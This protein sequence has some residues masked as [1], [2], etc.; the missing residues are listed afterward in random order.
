MMITSQEQET[1]E[2]SAHSH[3][4]LDA[5]LSTP[6]AETTIAIKDDDSSDSSQQQEGD[7]AASQPISPASTLP[8]APATVSNRRRKLKGSAVTKKSVRFN[9]SV[10][11]RPSLHKNDYTNQETSSCW[12][13]RQEY[14]SIRM[15]LLKTLKHIQSGN[16]LVGL[17]RRDA[18]TKIVVSSVSDAPVSDDDSIVTFKTEK[19]EPMDE[20]G[21]TDMDISNSRGLENYTVKGSLKSRVRKIRQKS[22]WEVLEEQDHQVDEAEYQKLTYLFYDD[23]AI[24]QA[25]IK[26]TRSAAAAARALGMADEREA[27]DDAMGAKLPGSRHQRR[28]SSCRKVSPKPNPLRRIQRRLSMLSTRKVKKSESPPKRRSLDDDR[29]ESDRMKEDCEK[30]RKH[31]MALQS[32]ELAWLT[33]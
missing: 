5:K 17:S 28:R 32:N 26:H 23:E 10:T 18:T 8:A 27:S 30:V 20:Y 15:G 1:C 24:R 33:V 22:I 13:S 6:G 21:E 9:T 16:P 19:T 25:Y 11:A 4:S 7:N 2:L 3:E 29:N 14:E 12:Y 31:F